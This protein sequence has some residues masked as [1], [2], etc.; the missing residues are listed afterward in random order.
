MKHYFA[1]VMGINCLWLYI[2][3][4]VREN[5]LVW[6]KIIKNCVVGFCWTSFT[7]YFRKWKKVERVFDEL[8]IR[9]YH[10]KYLIYLDGKYKKFIHIINWIE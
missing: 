5:L 9:K 4:A 1:C 8:A 7:W 3:V 6:K 10:Y 2:I